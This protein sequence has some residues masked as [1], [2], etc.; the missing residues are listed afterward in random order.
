[1]ILT[2]KTVDIFKF[3]SVRLA[4]DDIYPHYSY[5]KNFSLQEVQY[6]WRRSVEM[7]LDNKAPRKLGLYIHIPFCR[8]RCS[9]CFCDSYVPGGY[10]EVARYVGLLRRELDLFKKIFRPVSFTSIYFGGGSPSFLKLGDIVGL[11]EHI[12]RNFNTSSDCKVVFE[13]TP[14][15]LNK[16]LISVLARYNV[17]RLTI[18]VQSLDA[19]VI[20]LINRPQTRSKFVRV[21]KDARKAGIPFIN[22]DLIAGLEGQSIASFIRDLKDIIALGADMVHITPF[23]PLPHTPFSLA[24]KELSALEKQRRAIMLIEGRKILQ[25]LSRN[26]PV[27]DGFGLSDNDKAANAQETDL[28]KENSSLLGIGYSSHSHPF[29]QAWYGHPH[30][31]GSRHKPAFKRIPYFTGVKVCL[32]EEMR[33]FIIIN[34]F[35]GFLRSSF[36]A[37]FNKDPVEAFRKEF[38]ELENS[39]KIKIENDRII[40]RI[41]NRKEYLIYSKVFYSKARLCA[42]LQAAR[43]RYRKDKDYQRALDILFADF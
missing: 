12:Y 18:G 41:K 21:F 36:A 29:G 25:S 31:V 1:M 34:I 19:K 24:H 26:I 10:Q 23:S 37:L 30:L 22:V 42:I 40:S 32:E 33:K 17:N 8:F 6:F 15:D 11:F 7:I 39:G 4:D 2:P 20:R 38:Q 35:E 28:R 16:G 9:Y 27:E 13:G 3:L 5:G 14:T 43:P